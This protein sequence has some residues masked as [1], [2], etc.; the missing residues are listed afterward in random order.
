MLID[1]KNEVKKLIEEKNRGK[2]DEDKA[3]M[4][5]DLE[6]AAEEVEGAIREF[7]MHY[8][9]RELGRELDKID[10]DGSKIKRY[11]QDKVGEIV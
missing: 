11:I 5:R 7:E 4:D 3:I 1:I 2:K 9:Y 6:R 10:I 8:E